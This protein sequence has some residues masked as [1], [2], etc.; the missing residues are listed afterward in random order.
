M[1]CSDIPQ[2]WRVAELYRDASIIDQVQGFR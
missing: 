1:L 2:R